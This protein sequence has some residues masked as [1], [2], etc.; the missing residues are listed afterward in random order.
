MKKILFLF[1]TF[2]TVASSSFAQMKPYSGPSTSTQNGMMYRVMFDGWTST[3]KYDGT[4]SSKII[5]FQGEKGDV[6]SFDW[7]TST[8]EFCDKLVVSIDGSNVLAKSGD[9]NGSFEHQ[10][11]TTGEHI[12]EFIY[13]K[14]YFSSAGNDEVSINNIKVDY[15]G[16]ICAVTSYELRYGEEFG[17]WESVIN[18]RGE[19]F[20]VNATDGDSLLFTFLH[21]HAGSTGESDIRV[22]INKKTVLTSYWGEFY[23]GSTTSKAIGIPLTSGQNDIVFYRKGD[24]SYYYGL[25]AHYVAVSGLCFKHYYDN[26]KSCLKLNDDSKIR[27][28]YSTR[29]ND[30]EYSR[31]FNNTKWQALYV[32]FTMS[33]DDWK[34]DFEIA[35]INDIN[36]YDT[37]GDGEIDDTE[38]EI[39]RVTKGTLKPNHPYLIKAKTTG[40]KVIKLSDVMLY[41]KQDTIDVSSAEMKYTFIGTTN[42]ISG[43]DL[44][45]NHYYAMASGSLCQ[46]ESTS[47]DLKPFRWYMKVESRAPQVILPNTNNSR[48][49]IKV[50]GEDEATDIEDIEIA[51][52]NLTVYSLDGRVASTNGTEGLSKGIYIANGKKIIVK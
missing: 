36:M 43:K 52:D 30:F 11:S 49:R 17:Q 42:G 47:T 20:S 39:I 14:D 10:I 26:E 33:Y 7:K 19:G 46:T 12:V 35:K 48:I 41:P 50:L 24:Y 3:N 38:L 5:T 13:A 29:V 9:D 4:I 6:F 21:Y 16:K 28:D 23:E 40:N 1:F 45:D 25:T 44:V 37:D 2:F 31:T 34:N 32:P 18:D 15:C 22:K 27:V 51:S 8:E